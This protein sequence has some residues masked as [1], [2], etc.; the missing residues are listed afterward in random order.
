MA[1]IKLIPTVQALL[2]QVNELFPGTVSV[3]FGD[4]HAGYVRDDQVQQHV[5]KDRLLIW[6][7]DVTA[8]QY[9]AAH[10]LSHLL[11]LLQGFPQ[12]SF[13]LT[14]GDTELDGQL[15]A[16]ATQLFNVANHQV[17]FPA[18]AG[19]DLIDET[20]ASQY[21][22]GIFATIDPED[23]QQDDAQNALR[24]LVLLDACVFY[25][26]DID[27][28]ATELTTNFPITFAAA[29]KLYAVLTAKSAETPF[30]MR[31]SLV[32]LFKA[33]DEQLVAWGLP[34]L[35]STEF[36]TM[37]SVL[38]DR[39]LRLEMRQLFEVFH[40]D[41]QNRQTGKRAYV[42]LNRSDRQNA[43]VLTPPEDAENDSASYFKDVYDM[44]VK[45][46][47]DQQHIPY[48]IRD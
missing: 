26:A 39:Q 45:A 15:M 27:K 46:F 43:F 6:V 41:L 20:V 1:N 11:M 32:R 44:S 4:K 8:P 24:L 3:Q 47:F 28:H 5:L 7:D 19:H 29:Q 37:T 36:A 31:R 17:I 25:G 22:D 18:L 12:V 21:Y 30:G 34:P 10:E 42:G 40:S 33:F 13:D 9:S 14:F 23:G 38:S 16:L 35:H 48:S 2:D